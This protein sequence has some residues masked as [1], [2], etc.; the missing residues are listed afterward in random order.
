MADDV[1]IVGAGVAGAMLAWRLAEAGLKVTVLEAGPRVKREDALERFRGAVAKTPDSPYESTA[2]APRPVVGDLNSYY[3]QSGPDK[4]ASTYE[5]CVG[6]TTWHWLGTSIRLLPSD[7]RMKTRYGIGLDWPVTFD[8]LE[9]WY[10]KAEAQLGVAGDFK[11]HFAPRDSDF[12]LP[13]IKPSYLDQKMSAA[14]APLGIKVY[15]TPQA[16]NSVQF[17]DRPA[18]CGSANCIPICP[19]GAKYD[20]SVHVAMAEKAGARLIENAVACFVEVDAAGQVTGIR[21]KRPD[22]SEERATA[23]IYALAA[24]AIETPKLLLMS[25][26]EQLPAGVA[27]RSDQVGRNLMDHPTQLSWALCGEPIY[28]LRSPLTTSGIPMH[29]DGPFRKTQGAFRVEIGNDGW[30]WPVGAPSAL[31]P[32]FLARGVRGPALIDALRDKVARQF[33]LASLVEQLPS[34]DNR[35]VPAFD[36]PDAIGIPRPQINYQVDEY[37]LAGLKTARAFHEKVFKAMKSTEIAHED[38]YQGAGHIMGTHRMGTDPRT[39][40]VDSH[41]RAHDHPNLYLLGSGVFPTV[42]TGNPTLTL[43]AL[44]LRTAE[45]VLKQARG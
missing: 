8:E 30:T 22:G 37:T 32:G 14:L 2:Y 36:K 17:Q 45:E 12:P 3:V 38:T 27:N 40:V 16:R 33:R 35:V 7:M 5:R 23:R 1:L 20:A 6:G 18:C 29:R 26:T 28:P 39:S 42:G 25:R 31:V 15:P 11:D 4:F 43:A 34:P 41:G 19:I 10:E 44:A 9:P 24:H 13:P 21:Y